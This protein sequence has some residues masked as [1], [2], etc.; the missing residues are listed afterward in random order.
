MSSGAYEIRTLTKPDVVFFP[1]NIFVRVKIVIQ[2][3]HIKNNTVQFCI[4][5]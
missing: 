5:Q 2:K 4:S 3:K 1:I